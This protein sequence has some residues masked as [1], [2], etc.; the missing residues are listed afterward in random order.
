[1]RER[2]FGHWEGLT[3]NEIQELHRK[4]FHEWL[5]D[6]TGFKPSG[7]ESAGEV[8]QRVMP[9]FHEVVQRHPGQQIAVVAH[10]GVN[11]I[12][13][14]TLLRIPLEDLFTIEQDYAA[15]NILDFSADIP[16]IRSINHTVVLKE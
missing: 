3:F 2:H 12:I 14:C 16:S 11:R 9:L 15:L 7:G 5:G 8:Q 6:P 13:L 4:E 1:L 10:G